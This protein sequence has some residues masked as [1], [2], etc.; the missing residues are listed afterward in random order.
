MQ[1][2]ELISESIV[3]IRVHPWF[4]L[5]LVQSWRFAGQVPTVPGAGI[6]LPAQFGLGAHEG[7][8]APVYFTFHP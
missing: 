1:D 2:S 7:S 5:S 4:V 3:S 6:C 8:L